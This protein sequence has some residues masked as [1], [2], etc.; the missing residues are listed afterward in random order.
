MIIRILP[1]R[2]KGSQKKKKSKLTALDLLLRSS[3]AW[4]QENSMS[5]YL[6]ML[7][8]HLTKLKAK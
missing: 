7:H 6:Y 5:M 1:S 3:K 8:A 4:E 2:D